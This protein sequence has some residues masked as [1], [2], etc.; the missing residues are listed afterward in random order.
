M[1]A[2]TPNS[3]SWEGYNS[4][5]FVNDLWSACTAPTM[6]E[7]ALQM[8]PTLLHYSSAI[9]EQKKCWEFLAQNF[10]Q[11][12]TLYDDSQHHA[13]GCANGHNM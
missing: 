9:T 3:A 11:F 7:R 6:L 13:A 1:D 12:Q 10:D 4:Q 5:D 8:D 2:E